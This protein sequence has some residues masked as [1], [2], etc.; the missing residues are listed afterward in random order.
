MVGIDLVSVSRIEKATQNPRFKSEV[1]TES[2][3]AYCKTAQSFAGIYG[4]KEAFVKAIKTGLERS[5]F[6]EIE[7]LHDDS[8]AP[9]YNLS[10]KMKEILG[11]KKAHLSISHDGDYAIA[12]CLLEK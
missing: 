11:S 9:R 6:R 3:I 2:E 7:V 10:G 8:G 1:F 12:I 4:A 5:S